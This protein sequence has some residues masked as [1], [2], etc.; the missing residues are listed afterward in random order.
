[1]AGQ[2]PPKMN[3]CDTGVAFGIRLGWP[4]CWGA[5]VGMLTLGQSMEQLQLS[6]AWKSGIRS[7]PNLSPS[8]LT[9]FNHCSLAHEVTLM[10]DDC[11]CLK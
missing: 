6:I 5:L 7:D 1:M 3:F 11:S 9:H 8:I 10:T 2:T 4:S